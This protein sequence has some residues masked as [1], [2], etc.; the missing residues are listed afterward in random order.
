MQ[1]QEDPRPPAAFPIFI[2]S[3]RRRAHPS[4]RCLLAIKYLAGEGRRAH[5]A[6]SR[7]PW[8]ENVCANVRGDG[9]PADLGAGPRCQQRRPMVARSER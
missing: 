6:H 1:Q 8:Q 2:L 5:A 3:P 9:A 7:S 4:R